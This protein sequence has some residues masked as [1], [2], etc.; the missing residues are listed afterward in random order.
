[1]SGTHYIERSQ[2]AYSEHFT[3][4]LENARLLAP[5][6][7]GSL[8]ALTGIGSYFL[9]SERVGWT[10]LAIFVSAI[11]A[12]ILQAAE[13]K[14][15]ARNHQVL[16]EKYIRSDAA[17]LTD[18]Q[19]IAFNF[20]FK[21]L[22]GKKPTL[23][24]WNYSVYFGARRS[25]TLAVAC[26]WND[27]ELEVRAD[28]LFENIPH[29]KSCELSTLLNSQLK[30]GVSKRIGPLVDKGADPNVL[31]FEEFPLDKA[32][33]AGKHK[34][35]DALVGAG[36][37]LRSPSS[38]YYVEDLKNK[39]IVRLLDQGVILPENTTNQEHNALIKG[40]Y[41]ERAE[42]NAVLIICAWRRFQEETDDGELFMGIPEGSLKT[43]LALALGVEEEKI[44]LNQLAPFE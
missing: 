12:N 5:N 17:A 43:I 38:N 16:S 11:G 33:R 20:F 14:E 34:A 7:L 9:G 29:W 21:F 27:P 15:F 31:L 41:K 13:G 25:F 8:A 10:S 22:E 36:A 6:V 39:T 32:I 1:M 37:C 24:S 44:V 30:Q 18:E 40:F 3:F 23:Q 35:I 28:T 4:F 42:V 26:G 19:R 2:Y